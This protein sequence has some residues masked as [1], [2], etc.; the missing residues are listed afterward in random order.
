MTTIT[1]K[2]CFV[3]IDIAK[4]HLDLHSLPDGKSWRIDYAPATLKKLIADLL[5]APDVLVVME[6]SGGYE[7][8]CANLLADSGV[9]VCVTNP[10]K[11]RA[12]ARSLGQ[13]A[14][15]DQ[16]DARMLALYGERMQPTARHQHDPALA[17][18]V[19]LVA[20]RRDLVAMHSAETQRLDDKLVHPA[21]VRDIKR[22]VRALVRDTAS[23]ET[24]IAAQIA[25]H[26]L[27]AKLHSAFQAE[28]GVGDKTATAII[29]TM[30]ELGKLNRRE[31][32]ALAGLAPI[33]RDSGTSR[34]R[35]FTHG[36]RTEAKTALFMAAISAAR[37]HPTL[38]IFYKTLRNNGKPAKVALIAVARKLLIILNSIAK[39]E[40]TNPA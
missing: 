16:I 28:K 14:K 4:A 38:S 6:A 12:F 35:R 34:G 39:N 2:T 10:R 31:A 19:A 15:T 5:A 26:P 22:H 18:L 8:L 7:R 32:A 24:R 36:G 3:G 11:A 9:A 25:A 30:P 29:T 17:Q 21:L 37:Y 23:V 27:W 20:R 40:I 33:N 13:L 1:A